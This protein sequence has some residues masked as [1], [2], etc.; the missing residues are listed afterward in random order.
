MSLM[1]DN[2]VAFYNAFSGWINS[3]VIVAFIGYL[4][5]RYGYKKVKTRYDDSSDDR[6]YKNEQHLRKD[7][8]EATDRINKMIDSNTNLQQSNMELQQSNKDLQTKAD[9]LIKTVDQQKNI[10]IQQSEI[11]EN[12]NVKIKEW[13]VKIESFTSEN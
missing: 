5:T 4:S 11:I 9:S 6:V 8:L 12:L 3:G 1:I 13:L 7:W 10:M 2:I